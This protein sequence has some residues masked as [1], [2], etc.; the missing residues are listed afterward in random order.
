MDELS[1]KLFLP[2]YPQIDPILELLLIIINNN[3][4]WDANCNTNTSV[5][6]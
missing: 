4:N 6:K 5:G 3:A 2:Y 1:E